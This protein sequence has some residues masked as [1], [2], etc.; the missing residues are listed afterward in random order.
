[1]GRARRIHYIALKIS[2]TGYLRAHVSKNNKPKS[3]PV[4]RA[5]AE[6]FIENPDNK[7][8]VN[9]KNGDKTD[10][11]VE[12]LEWVSP[13]ENRIHAL[14]TLDHRTTGKKCVCIE[15]GKSFESM[16]QAEKATGVPHQNIQKC[17]V[18]KRTQAGG[19]HWKY[20]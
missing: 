8:Q 3:I 16:M 11:R 18:G 6:A 4:H 9:H 15:T 19:Y 17:A 14:K 5:V 12:N 7:A 20:A 2:N 10:N 1:M 13:S